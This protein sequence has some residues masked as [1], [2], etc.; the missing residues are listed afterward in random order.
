M[1]DWCRKR[2]AEAAARSN[3]PVRGYYSLTAPVSEET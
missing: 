3:R 2:R 1:F